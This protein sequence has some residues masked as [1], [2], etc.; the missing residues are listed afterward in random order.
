MHDRF[1]FVDS[2]EINYKR[3]DFDLTGWTSC[4]R[5]N[6]G[7][8]VAMD[9]YRPGPFLKLG[10]ELR[11]RVRSLLCWY[12]SW[13]SLVMFVMV[14]SPFFLAGRVPAVVAVSL[15]VIAI[16]TVV[17]LRWSSVAQRLHSLE[18]VVTSQEQ[19]LS[20]QH[21]AIRRVTRDLLAL[22]HSVNEQELDFEGRISDSE[23]YELK[24]QQALL[25]FQQAI[26][27]LVGESLSRIESLAVA[28]R[29]RFEALAR[30]D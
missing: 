1:L 7:M 23:Q 16:S 22:H 17:P 29:L 20:L 11:R 13:T 24:R 9:S 18:E 8:F 30:S 15:P 25:Q 26:L 6:C 4:E 5:A 10:L 12:R 14:I 19:A 2:F 28:E 21:E 3:T 27:A